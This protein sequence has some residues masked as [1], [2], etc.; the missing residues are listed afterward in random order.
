MCVDGE[1][2]LVY[3]GENPPVSREGDYMA[4]GLRRCKEGIYIYLLSIIQNI[5]VQA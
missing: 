3:M 1:M 2:C 4:G 5:S